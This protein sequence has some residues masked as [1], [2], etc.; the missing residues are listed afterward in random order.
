[1]GVVRGL[2]VLPPRREPYEIVHQDIVESADVCVI[3]SGAGGAVVAHELACAGRS[4]VLLERGGYYEGRDMN[5]RDADMVPLLWK[6]GGFN[7]DDSMSVAIA[8]GQCLGGST[9]INDAVCFDT[10]PRVRAEWRALGVDFTDE[11]W[12]EHHARVKSMIHAHRVTEEE[13]NRNNRMLRAGAQ[14]LGLRDHWSNERNC[15]NCMQCGFCHDGCHYE[16]KQNMLVTYI[17]DALHRPEAEVRIYCNC[18]A[19]ELLLRDGRVEAV[20][21]RFLDA[22]GKVRHRLRVNAKVF[23]VAAGAIESSFLLLR[24]GIATETA[25]RGVCL[26]PSLLMSGQF[27]YE[28]RANQGIPMAY[29]IH[30]FGVLRTQETSR[31]ERGVREGEFLIESIS[32][33]LFEY[34]MGLPGAPLDHHE[35]LERVHQ[36]AITGVLARDHSRGRVAVRPDGSKSFTYDLDA[37]DRASLAMACTIAGEMWF[38]LGA[39]RVATRHADVPY[40]HSKEELARLSEAIRSPDRPMQI[41]SAHPQS[42]NAIGADPTTSTVDSDCRVHG[43]TNLFVCDASVFPNAV[44][45]NPQLTVMVTASIAA[46]RMVRDWD[47]RYATIPLSAGVLASNRV[48]RPAQG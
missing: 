32:L 37:V 29:A 10:P 7:F 23:V 22:G 26:H 39:E 17:R 44:G 1:M 45:V 14:K 12:A 36:V 21:G 15:V 33:P 34:S 42:G 19:D 43:Y 27:P 48:S 25:G 18:A 11:E 20:V 40:V 35:F 4:V 41:A 38:A 28:I 3:G 6:T 24:N 13:L 16:T 46:S 8:Q 47:R 30:D 2:E 9:V 31:E 5:Q